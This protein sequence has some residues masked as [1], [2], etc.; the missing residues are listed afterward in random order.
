MLYSLW[1]YG[2]LPGYGVW[3]F[4]AVR[5]AHR[6]NTAP[7]APR[8]LPLPFWQHYLKSCAAFPLLCLGLVASTLI[9]SGRPR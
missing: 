7:A 4:V 8:R 6:R 5:N 1:A 3:L 2:V 9:W